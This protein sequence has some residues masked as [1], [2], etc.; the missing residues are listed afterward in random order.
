MEVKEIKS[1]GY[2]EKV[3]ATGITLIDF[4]APWY[5]PCRLQEPI[6]K[7][8]AVQFEGNVLIT[9]MNL[10]KN[11]DVALNLGIHSIPTLIIFKNGKEIQRFVGLQSED[12]LSEA[13][14]KLLK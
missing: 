6:I 10:E 9:T 13:L 7:Q 2:L 1:K 3:I 4:S 5:A 8:L 11:R 12:T 14:R